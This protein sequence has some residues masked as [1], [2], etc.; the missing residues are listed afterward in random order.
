MGCFVVLAALASLGQGIGPN[1]S[2]ADLKGKFLEGESELNLGGA[3]PGEVM[4]FGDRAVVLAGAADGKQVRPAAVAA[5]FG[6]GRVA[7]LG[8]GALLQ[9]AAPV[10]KLLAW[11]SGP[12]GRIGVFGNP[13][14]GFPGLAFERVGPQGLQGVGAVVVSSGDIGT[15]VSVADLTEFVRGGK[16]LLVLDTPWGWLQTHPGK[17]LA[18]DH[19]GNELLEV[20]GIGFAAGTLDN[21]SGKLP[22]IAPIDALHAGRALQIFEGTDQPSAENGTAIGAVLA[23][24]LRDGR[25]GSDF[26][27]RVV[28]AVKGTAGSAFPIA[29]KPV[30][31]KDF[32]ARIGLTFADM[33]W[34]RLPVNRVVA[35]PAA[36][37]FPGIVDP[38]AP[39]ES[40]VVAIESGKRRWRSTGRYAAPGETVT[41]TLS[42]EL[43]GKPVGLRIGGH[44]DQLWGLDK[45]DRCPSIDLEVRITGGSV[46]AANP[47]GGMVYITCDQPL[48]AGS[49]VL[50]G[51]VEAPVY[52]LGQTTPAQW[53]SLRLS[54][55]PWGEIVGRHSAIC[56][57]SRVL[58]TLDDPKLVAEY[59]DEMVAEAEKLYAVDP[60][61]TEHRYQVDRQISA[62]YMHAGYPIMTWEDVSEKFVNI[63]I[64]RGSTGN[65]NWGFYHEL[66]H[67]YQRGE[68]TWNGW[69]E[70]TNNLFSLYA[71][72]HFNG[73]IVGIGAMTEDQVQKRLAEVKANPGSKSFYNLDPWYGLSFWEMLRREFGFNSFT[74]YFAWCKGQQIGQDQA[75][76]DAFLVEM[77][78]IVGHDLARYGE[79]WGIKFS[80]TAK[81]KTSAYPEWLPKEFK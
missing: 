75:R 33:E 53:R 23:S 50:A 35:S 63:S 38:T 25:K 64:L 72:Q 12:A 68:W 19:P 22:L 55:A 54:G 5:D 66:G 62:G 73:Q 81:A 11:L 1:P 57:P 74:Q 41:A 31:A 10:V 47:F 2:L 59:F 15:R 42:P 6:Q 70:I 46:Q 69:G 34:R 79:M 67:N 48:P 24:V 39:R 8:H 16:G 32:R 9:P 21:K 52:F 78:R 77:S 45:W 36:A 60:G 65:P 13:P 61:T 71:C 3:L 51:T 44:K 20:M 4:A 26:V 30:L 40:A 18:E 58:K 49:V 43:V 56:V 7:A 29:G 27:N 14:S 17:T 28:T 80:A 37:D 76:K